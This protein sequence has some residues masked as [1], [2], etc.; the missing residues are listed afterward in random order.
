MIIHSRDDWGAKAPKSVTP[1]TPGSFL[2]TVVHWFG[3]PVASKSHAGCDDLLRGVQN[4][5]MSNKEEG[6][7]D[8]AYNMAF[9]PHGHAYTLRGI[10]RQGGA[11]GTT[12]ANHDYIAIVYMAGKGDLFPQPAE[13]ALTDLLHWAWDSGVGKIVRTHGSITGSECPGPLV[14]KYVDDKEYLTV[15]PKP[16]ALRVDVVTK[17]FK[18]S[19]QVY[20][21]PAVQARITRALNSGFEVKLSPSKKGT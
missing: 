19:D 10:N 1:R 20:K 13:E 17:E 2:G 21:N 9:C 5:H 12:Q 16:K 11:N 8:I 6:Y 7:V 4:A 15:P 3:S 14:K 18:L